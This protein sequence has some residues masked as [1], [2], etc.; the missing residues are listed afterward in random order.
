[1]NFFLRTK[2]PIG[3]EEALKRLHSF[4]NSHG[5]EIFGSDLRALLIDSLALNPK[6]RPS[7]SAIQNLIA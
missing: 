1:M 6:D 4:L 3:T 5:E 7:V 2:K